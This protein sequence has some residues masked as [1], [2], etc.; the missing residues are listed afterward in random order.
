VLMLDMSWS[1]P[2][3]G[4]FFAA[5]KVTLA[6]DA[7]IRSQFPRDNLYIVGFSD[8]AREIKKEQ[9][10]HINWNEYVYGTNMHH[11]FILSRQLLAKHKSGSKQIIMVTDG[12]PT[13]H[14]ERGISYF[15]YPPDPRTLQL[16]L[17]EAKRCAQEGIVI[18]TFMLDR[19]PSIMQFIDLLT[20]TNRGRVFYTDRENLG[21]Y[22]LVD[23][24]ANKRKRI[25][26]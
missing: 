15:D 23:Y 16:T 14:L 13:A 3:R 26:C 6:L 4:N 9:L 11:G 2:M 19:D 1:M 24:L 25:I 17:L 22:I 18:N 8:Y 5:K 21:R 7:L 20:R 12:E 10:P